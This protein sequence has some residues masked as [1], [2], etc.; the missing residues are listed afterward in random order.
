M[1]HVALLLLL[2]TITYAKAQIDTNNGDIAQSI[3]VAKNDLLDTSETVWEQTTA[4]FE[5]MNLIWD[6]VATNTSQLYITSDQTDVKEMLT[7]P[8]CVVGLPI[9]HEYNSTLTHVFMCCHRRRFSPLRR[10]VHLATSMLTDGTTDSVGTTPEKVLTNIGE[11]M[12]TDMQGYV[13]RACKDDISIHVPEQNIINSV[14]YNV[15]AGEI[16]SMYQFVQISI[17]SLLSCIYEPVLPPYCISSTPLMLANMSIPSLLYESNPNF[18]VFCN[19]GKLQAYETY[20]TSAK[21]QQSDWQKA[22]LGASSL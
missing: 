6:Q 14:G 3:V 9:E 12:K 7:I 15:V 11:M 5:Q 21:C 18:A 8:A 10:I 22:L 1:N 16:L 13:S 2:T 17:S 19:F 4:M 20:R